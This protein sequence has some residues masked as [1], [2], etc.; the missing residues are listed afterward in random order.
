[1]TPAEI[2]AAVAASPELLALRTTQAATADLAAIAAALSVGT[3]LVSHFASER[4][5]LDRYPGGP[6]AA[7]ALLVKLEGFAASAHPLAGIVK[8]ALKFLGTPEGIDLGS[9]GVQTILAALTP[10][11]LSVQERDGLIA[12]ASEPV[13]VT[14]AEV[15]AALF[16]DDGSAA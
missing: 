2:R 15:Q 12:M 4:G 13:V 9:F 14:P 11:V 5:I 3:R 16:N 6:A 1:M 10:G 7:D 8:R